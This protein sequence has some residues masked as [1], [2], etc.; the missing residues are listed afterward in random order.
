M[1]ELRYD[2]PLPS[3]PALTDD[4]F[5]SITM[6]ID[7]QVV[8]VLR[9]HAPGDESNTQ[10]VVQILLLEIAEPFRRR[11]FGR[12]LL[13]AA[14]A[15]AKQWHVSK[16]AKLRRFWIAVEQKHQ[17]VARAFLTS[18]GFHH[19]TTVQGVTRR[20]DLLVYVKAFD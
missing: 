6:F 17:V 4:W 3:K 12:D 19:T 5:Q 11:A 9:W 7:G 20:Q 13:N 8:G 2:P 16:A 15:Q 18:R 1:T 10:G 14:V